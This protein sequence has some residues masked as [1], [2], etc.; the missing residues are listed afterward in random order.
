MSVYVCVC[1]CVCVCF[2]WK[3]WSGR[4]NS[5]EVKFRVI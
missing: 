4:Y 2:T 5:L 3:T 1:V